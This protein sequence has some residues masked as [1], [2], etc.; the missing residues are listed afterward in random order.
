MR[1]RLVLHGHCANACLAS[2]SHNGDIL[3]FVATKHNSPRPSL[4]RLYLPSVTAVHVSFAD[5]TSPPDERHAVFHQLAPLRSSSDDHRTADEATTTQNRGITVDF[6]FYS[7]P[8]QN[9]AESGEKNAS[10]K[11]DSSGKPASAVQPSCAGGGGVELIGRLSSCTA[12]DIRDVNSIPNSE[13]SSDHLPV[14][15]QFQL[16]A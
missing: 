7:P 3:C 2:C 12:Q 11:S 14:V 4:R 16:R 1:S 8:P 9:C 5:R 6:I 13:H 10:A 15:A